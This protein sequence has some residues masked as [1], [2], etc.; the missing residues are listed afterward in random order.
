MAYNQITYPATSMEDVSGYIN[1][2]G[3]GTRLQGMVLEHPEF[4][5]AK[6]LLE[7]G[8][9]P[10]K[11]VDHHIAK[12][13]DA[14]IGSIVVGAGH[15]PHVVEY[16]NDI[17][18]QDGDVQP[19]M[20]SRQLGSGRELYE[21]IKQHP[22]RFNRH[23]YICNVDTIVDISERDF[24]RFH[25]T[26]GALLSIALT[27]N[28]GVPN[29]GAYHVAQNGNV[30][31]CAEAAVAAPTKESSEEAIARGSSTGAVVV[32]ADFM[33]DYH[34]DFPDEGEFSL[35]RHVIGQA[36]QLGSLRG[37]DNGRKFFMDVGV[38]FTYTAA[39]QTN[40]L[41]PYLHYGLASRETA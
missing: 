3:R 40:L 16:V 33:Q 35:Y 21:A 27:Q 20:T 37:Y 23:I 34:W 29:E 13:R 39:T 28:T 19:A 41:A 31:Y 11:L 8:N 4:G 24:V 38:P 18:G 14:G 32:D 7:V 30:T 17:Y 6:A 36:L 2:G 10:I 9:P 22:D 26:G 25:K 15:Q 1:A 12:M 5:I